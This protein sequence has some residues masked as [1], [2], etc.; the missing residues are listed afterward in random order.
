MKILPNFLSFIFQ[1][2]ILLNNKIKEAMN[3]IKNNSNINQE[4]IDNLNK[5]KD[6]YNNYFK[7]EG[8]FYNNIINDVYNNENFLLFDEKENKEFKNILLL[9]LNS[10]QNS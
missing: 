10:L 7:N 1:C 2:N 6:I 4:I 3:F 9:L 5:Y 8:E